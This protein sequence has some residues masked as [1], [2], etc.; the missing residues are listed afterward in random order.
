[1]DQALGRYRWF[2]SHSSAHLARFLGEGSI[3]RSPGYGPAMKRLARGLPPFLHAHSGLVL[4]F[5]CVATR[6]AS[7]DIRYVVSLVSPERHL[8]QVT[9]ELPPG[10]NTHEV[11]LPVW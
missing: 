9:M 10:R 1:M 2:R 5:C 6:L 7:A 3:R 4:L 11:Q 8:V